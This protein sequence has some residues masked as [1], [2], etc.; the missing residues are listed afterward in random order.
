MGNL[1]NM[2]RI[3]IVLILSFFL[4]VSATAQTRRALVIGIGEQQDKN[5]AKING[6]KDV[7][8]VQQLLTSTGYKDVRTIVNQQA[9]KIG[10]VSAFKKLASQCSVGDVVYVHFSGYEQL[11]TDINGDEYDGWDEAWIPYDAYKK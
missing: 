10:I 5:W 3:N 4:S 7:L 1:P 6:D 2:S 8:Y 9:S 11:V